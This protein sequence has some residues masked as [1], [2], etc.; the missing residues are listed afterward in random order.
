MWQEYTNQQ[1]EIANLQGAARHLRNM[2]K[3]KHG[4]KADTNDKFA[5]GFFADRSL[6]VVGRAKHL[7]RRLDRLLTED[8]IEKPKP[9]WQMKIE[10]NRAYKNSRASVAFEQLSIGY[11]QKVVLQGLNQTIKYGERLVLIGP[12][13]S[14]KTTLL[15]TIAGVIPA[16][17]GSIHIGP[18][19]QIGHMAQEPE[20]LGVDENVLAYFIQQVS[21]PETEARSFLSKYLFKGDDVF[22]SLPSLSY[23]ER[24]RLALACLVARGCNFL[25][26]DEP[27]NHLDIPA[28]ANFEQAL[29]GFEGTVLAVVHDR[30]FMER[31]ATTIWQVEGSGLRVIK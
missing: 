30:Y 10:F 2:A 16:L 3:F 18:S 21:L 31:F 4:G 8:K 5:K 1:D 24:A 27:F 17:Y 7:E 11:Q 28:R 26:L 19:V 29:A 6:E 14:G 22:V 9:D 12:N 13:G 20:G 15:R 25:L 23:G